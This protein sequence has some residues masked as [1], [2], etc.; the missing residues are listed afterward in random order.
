MAI[1]S[2]MLTDAPM[3]ASRILNYFW[4]KSHTWMDSYVKCLVFPLNES[5]ARITD[6]L[7]Y[8]AKLTQFDN[9]NIGVQ[10][11]CDSYYDPR[12]K[13][14]Q[15]TN[16]PAS[17]QNITLY[18]Y[19][20]AQLDFNSYCN[21]VWT[22]EYDYDDDVLSGYSYGTFDAYCSWSVEN[23]EYTF[24]EALIWY[25]SPMDM[26]F[27]AYDETISYYD[28]YIKLHSNIYNSL[29][30]DGRQ[31]LKN[32]LKAWLPIDRTFEI[33]AHNDNIHNDYI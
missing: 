23:N 20:P 10:A 27:V 24:D 30:A 19:G 32:E 3:L 17:S 9:S 31:K 12:Q 11:Y 1:F 14:T 22:I 8:D 26:E 13:R 6:R 18:S 25:L 4:R 21:S 2:R 5:Q 15:V 33:F 29:G 16:N 28:F 7:N